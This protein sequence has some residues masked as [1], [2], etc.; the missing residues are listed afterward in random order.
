MKHKTKLAAL[1]AGLTLAGSSA[2]TAQTQ[3]T[4]P[5]FVDV[6]GG[7]QTQSRTLNT[8]TSFP[9]YGETAVINSAQG[10]DG[11]GL[12]DI[13]GG[14][15]IFRQFSIGIGFS[16]FSK[17]GTG[18]IAASIPNPAVINRPATS[19]T[20]G[21]GLKH[22]ELGTHLLFIWSQPIPMYRKIE[23]AIFAGPSF[24]QLTQDVLTATVPTGTQT[25]NVASESQKATA[26]GAN[27]GVSFNYMVKPNYGAGVFIRYAGGTA[28]LAAG[29][30]KV[31][32]LQLGGGLR[33]KF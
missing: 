22:R 24:I 5:I 23:A 21:T 4:K 10:I 1:I 9:L 6:N 33:L 17:T 20:S 13:S 25:A 26:K 19:T 32:G 14:Y 27:V 29:S 11:G 12:F 16:A 28:K 7:A 31:G 2:A 3:T 8:T 15:R 18:M 30:V